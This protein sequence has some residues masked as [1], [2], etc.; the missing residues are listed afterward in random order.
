MTTIYLTTDRLCPAELGCYDRAA[1][2]RDAFALVRQAVLVAV[3]PFDAAR[4]LDELAQVE[5]AT[6][7][8]DLRLLG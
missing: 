6:S 5:R 8:D 4:L 2:V 3:N 1:A 7:L